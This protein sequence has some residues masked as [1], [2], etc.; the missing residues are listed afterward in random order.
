M[1]G[2]LNLVLLVVTT[3]LECYRL[4]LLVIF[5]FSREIG[6]GSEGLVQEMQDVLEASYSEMLNAL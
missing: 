1:I 3:S 6:S 5:Y 2:S 4:V